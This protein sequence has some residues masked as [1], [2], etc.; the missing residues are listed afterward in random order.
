MARSL[1]YGGDD[2]CCNGYAPTTRLGVEI[3]PI[4]SEERDYGK[5]WK[6]RLL[7]PISAKRGANQTEAMRDWWALRGSSAQV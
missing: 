2:D 6:S 3:L 5:R 1:I 7:V 4:V